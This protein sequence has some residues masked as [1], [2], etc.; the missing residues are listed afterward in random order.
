VEKLFFGIMML[1]HVSSAFPVSG[2]LSEIIGYKVVANTVFKFSIDKKKACFFAF[3]TTNPD[4][5][6]DIGGN[7]NAGDSIWYGYYKIRSPD[8]IHE[9]PKPSDTDWS[10]VCSINAIS[11]YDMNG[12]KK[13]DV[14]VV[15]SC[16][17]NSI[18]YTI[19]FVF[20]QKDNKY[21]FDESVYKNLYGFIDLTITDV[22]AYIKSPKSYFKVLE[23]RNKKWALT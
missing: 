9:F 10:S 18:N 1:V 22:R 14:T 19:P 23:E 16:N 15:G 6:I 3:Y 5:I 4:P 12:D 20:I 7:G 21:T 2:C 13:P 17:K 11:F 8:K